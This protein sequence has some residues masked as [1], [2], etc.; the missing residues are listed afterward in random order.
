MISSPEK[1]RKPWRNRSPRQN[2]SFILL[3]FIKKEKMGIKR[4]NMF[5]L[6]LNKTEINIPFFVE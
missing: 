6:K 5:I 1:K 2:Y 4:K 3:S